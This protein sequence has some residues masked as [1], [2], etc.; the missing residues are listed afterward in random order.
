MKDFIQNLASDLLR[1]EVNTIIKEDLTCQKPGSLRQTLLN[2]AR[3]YRLKLIELEAFIDPGPQEELHPDAADEEEGRKFNERH[4]GVPAYQ[5]IFNFAESLKKRYQHGL[6]EPERK[7]KERLKSRLVMIDRIMKQSK[8]II[9]A[10]KEL[11]EELSQNGSPQENEISNSYSANEVDDMEDLQM[12]PANVALIRKAGEIGTQ[13]VLMQTVVQVEGDIT[14][15]IT[16]RFLN[17]TEDDRQVLTGVH[18]E[19]IKSSISMWQYL[20]KT[21]TSLAGGAI[22]G[23]MSGGK[24]QVGS[25]K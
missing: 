5:E 23:M 11:K 4:G 25:G 8:L 24:K 3:K 22:G 9:G 16:P 20:F 21:I 1:L 19:A 2:L 6:F 17:L 18:S 12:N 15:Y 13:R 14:T 10:F 7:E